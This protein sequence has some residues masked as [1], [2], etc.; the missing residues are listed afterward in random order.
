MTYKLSDICTI[1][2]GDTGIMKAIPGK[3]AMITL[4]EEDKTHNEF[5]FDAKAV[6]VPLISSTGHGHASMKRVKYFEGKFALGNILSAVIAKDETK[7]NA[8]YLHIYLH[9]NRE[10][11]LVPLM[12]G[13]ANVSLPITRLENV[14]VV[15]PSIKKQLEIVEQYKTITNKNNQLANAFADQSQ[16]LSQ[17]RQSILQEAI[18]GKLTA[19]WREQN[20]NI[21]PAAELLK[22][23]K[24]EREK[25]EGR[26]QKGK[27]FLPIAENEIPFELP[28]GWV[29]CR[30]L[31]LVTYRKG[32]RPSILS[33]KSD[34][35]LTIPY[36]D[37]A[38]FEKN[39]ISNYTNDKKSV[40]C[41]PENILLVWDGARM[42]LV[43]KGVEGAVGSTLV[44]I[45]VIQCNIEYIFKLLQSYFSF[46][47]RNPKQAGLPHM[48][49]D[50]LDKLVIALPPLSEQ[51]VIVE[52]VEALLGKCNQLQ[53][54]IEKLNKHSKDLLKALFNETFEN[55]N[56]E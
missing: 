14:K 36:I 4:G 11:L 45:D 40:F 18:Q 21:E 35:D 31:D 20:P 52:K 50:L 26:R 47:N 3:Y 28:E 1:T 55:K 13:A 48:N 2:K 54:E 38:A 42:G 15:I 7:V 53:E 49:G 22:R 25:A 39:I 6:I 33:N 10:K 44:K 32:K 17:L 9:E 34:N 27:T 8:K 30:F 19:K 29:W 37:I 51:Q 16:L 24:A 46:F 56:D 5:Q 43:G 12:K 23:I 41:E